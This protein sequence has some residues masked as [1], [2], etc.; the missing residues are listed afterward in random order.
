[1]VGKLKNDADLFQVEA[2][3]CQD[4]EGSQSLD[5]AVRS[6]IGPLKYSTKTM[7]HSVFT[8]T[9]IDQ[10]AVWLPVSSLWNQPYTPKGINAFNFC[11]CV[12]A[13]ER[14]RVR[15]CKILTV[16]LPYVFGAEISWK[17]Q[18]N[19]TTLH[20][21]KILIMLFHNHNSFQIPS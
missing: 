8:L 16:S 20:M 11:V 2:T 18:H 5:S 4:P 7:K 9:E 21:A 6:Q 1:M 17:N 15:V 19:Y 10:P 13:C 12:R 3:H 14:V